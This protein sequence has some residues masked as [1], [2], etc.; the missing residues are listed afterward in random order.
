MRKFIAIFS[1]FLF[2]SLS[3]NTIRPMAKDSTTTSAS[4]QTY[5]EGFYSPSDL[6][7][8]PNVMYKV[9]NVSPHGTFMIIFDNNQLIQQ[10]IRLE[11]N[12][13]QYVLKPMQFNHKIVI[14]GNGQLSFTT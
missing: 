4:A 1:V 9:R 5:S 11:P 7:L 10:S 12:S 14:I 6:K 13:I 3:I 8:M 2:I